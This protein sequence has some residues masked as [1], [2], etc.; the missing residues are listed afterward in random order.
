MEFFHSLG[1]KYSVLIKIIKTFLLG[2][3]RLFILAA[4]FALSMIV[5]VP[6]LTVPLIIFINGLTQ[7][8][9]DP[10]QSEVL[11]LAKL[12]LVYI[13]IAIC[14]VIGYFLNANNSKWWKLWD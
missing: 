8:T 6:V 14:C 10:G 2:F 9:N 12:D 1:T 7:L 13:A 11:F 3:G 4:F 5:A